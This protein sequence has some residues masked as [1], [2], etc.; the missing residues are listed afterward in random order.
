MVAGLS[1]DR[2]GVS[3]FVHGPIEPGEDPSAAA[4]RV[5]REVAGI[6]TGAHQPVL[7]GAHTHP[8]RQAQWPTVTV[9]F[10]VFGQIENELSA[11][12]IDFRVFD[13]IES[14]SLRSPTVLECAVEELRQLVVSTPVAGR[15]AAN[16]YG[17]FT[18]LD[19]RQVFEAV[20]DKKLDPANFRRQ[21]EAIEGLLVERPDDQN[22][23]PE[24]SSYRNLPRGR[25]RRPVVYR[26]APTT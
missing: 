16:K 23:Y 26:L 11:P 18:L 20:L 12:W 1:T 17:L 22:K 8:H 13:E 19:L 2:K 3:D 15:V 6:R 21:A 9:S 4:D 25:G 24:G 7:V 10:M 5:L 14:A